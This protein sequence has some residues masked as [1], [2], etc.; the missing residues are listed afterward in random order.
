MG[1]AA[2]AAVTGTDGKAVAADKKFTI[3][4]VSALT[5]DTFYITMHRGAEAA[6][7]AVGA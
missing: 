4:L 5:N 3:A 1:V 7:K 2:A 6:A